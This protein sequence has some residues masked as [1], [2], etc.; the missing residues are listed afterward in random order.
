MMCVHMWERERER[1]KDL[2]TSCKW[3]DLCVRATSH[4]VSSVLH[5]TCL[6]SGRHTACGNEALL[7]FFFWQMFSQEA[8]PISLFRL[9]CDKHPHKEGCG[10]SIRSKFSSSCCH[11]SIFNQAFPSLL[12]VYSIDWYKTYHLLKAGTLYRLPTFFWCHIRVLGG[13]LTAI[14]LCVTAQVSLFVSL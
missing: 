5:L 11:Y 2:H 12:P 13:T 7:L 10:Q 14:R 8:L 6:R 9:I 4:G 1:K 3:W